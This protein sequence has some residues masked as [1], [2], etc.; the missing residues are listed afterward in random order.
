LPDPPKI[1]EK[2][3]EAEL[4]IPPTTVLQLLAVLPEPKITLFS[5]L[6]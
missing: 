3:P 4:Q 6:N 2:L 1:P 5:L